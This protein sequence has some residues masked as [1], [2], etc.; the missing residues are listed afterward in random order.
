MSRIRVVGTEPLLSHPD[1]HSHLYRA[2]P[3]VGVMSRRQLQRGTRANVVTMRSDQSGETAAAD[4]GPNSEP[5][6]WVSL[7]RA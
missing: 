1:V 4:A 3:K 5:S 2:F 7:L 6:R